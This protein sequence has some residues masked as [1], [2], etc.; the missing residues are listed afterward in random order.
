MSGV[1]TISVTFSST[2]VKVHARGSRDC[3]LKVSDECDYANFNPDA[4][5]QEKQSLEGQITNSQVVISDPTTGRFR[6]ED[7]PTI[8]RGANIKNTNCLPAEGDPFFSRFTKVYVVSEAEKAKAAGTDQM[9]NKATRAI[10]EKSHKL[11][12]VSLRFLGSLSLITNLLG[13]FVTV[14]KADVTVFELFIHG[15]RE[16]GKLMHPVRCRVRRVC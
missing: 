3:R 12:M 13:H 9:S 7:C 14:P 5:S 11:A 15:F 4:K 16:V 6:V 10:D 1:N 2:K 8:E